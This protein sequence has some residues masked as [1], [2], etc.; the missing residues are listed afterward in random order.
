MNYHWGN[1][2]ALRLGPGANFN[3]VENNRFEQ[4]RENGILIGDA[5]GDACMLNIITG[6][7]IHTNSEG[8]SGTFNAVEAHNAFDTTFT[9]N[10]IF[11]WNSDATKAKSGV[12]ITDN[13]RRWIVK[14]NIIRHCA[15]KPI[16][17]GSE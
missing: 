2:V 7:T 15:D 6:N 8:N 11:S 9:T 10:Q 4:S 1:V 5:K 3:R 16:V 17:Y 14:D 12:V 13:C